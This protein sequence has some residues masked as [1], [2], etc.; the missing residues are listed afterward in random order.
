[1]VLRKIER[2]F[3]IWES[4]VDSSYYFALA[5]LRAQGFSHQEAAKRLRERWQRA[6]AEHHQTN[7]RIAQAILRRLG[8][9]RN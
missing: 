8:G 5:G 2:K 4:L 1:M 7:R 9:K 6:L 3:R